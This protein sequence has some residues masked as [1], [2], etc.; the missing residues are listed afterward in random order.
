MRRAQTQGG[1]PPLSAI[2]V[3]YS[4]A[5]RRIDRFGATESRR[6]KQTGWPLTLVRLPFGSHVKVICANSNYCFHSTQKAHGRPLSTFEVKM[7]CREKKD[8]T[9]CYYTH[10][11]DMGKIMWSLTKVKGQVRRGEV[12]NKWGLILRLRL[13]LS[14][15]RRVG[16]AIGP[17]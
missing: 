13:C 17:G 14:L 10:E 12:N 2:G 4:L 5:L 8:A 9:Q 6:D 7:R 15:W 1:H 11:G 3:Y 16:F